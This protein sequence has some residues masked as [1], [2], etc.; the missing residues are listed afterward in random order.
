MDKRKLYVIFTI[1]I[2]ALLPS[3]VFASVIIDQSYGVTTST[4]TNPIVMT[5]GPNYAVAHDLG[6]TTLK[7][8]IYSPS[9]N[10]IT[11]GYVANDTYVELLN[12]LEINNNSKVSS[13]IGTVT[14]DLYLDLPSADVNKTTGTDNITIYY[15]SS[16]ATTTFPSFSSAS[17]TGLGTAISTNS[18]ATTTIHIT[19][20]SVT[21]VTVEYIS[22]V[23]TGNLPNAAT[24]CMNY[25]IA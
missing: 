11:F 25:Q 14:V 12:V 23:I 15:C 16:P 21:P 9:G 6:F 10:N 13:S 18:L 8:G 3:A 7:N 4:P 24:L 20:T 19:T 22:V 5:Q 17:I 2:V 1:I